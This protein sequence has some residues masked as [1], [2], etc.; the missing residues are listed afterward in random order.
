MKLE[1]ELFDRDATDRRQG[2]R[3]PR[4]WIKP[5]ATV[6]DVGINRVAAETGKSKLVGDGAFARVLGVAGRITPCPGA[7]DR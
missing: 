1:A 7:S 6:I 5:D 4:D 2:F 3:R